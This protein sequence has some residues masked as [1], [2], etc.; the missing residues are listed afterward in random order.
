LIVTSR[1][2]NNNPNLVNIYRLRIKIINVVRII[3]SRC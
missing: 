1:Y 2:K 3:F